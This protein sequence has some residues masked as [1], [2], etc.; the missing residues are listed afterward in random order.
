MFK[1]VEP[2]QSLCSF[3]CN[4]KILTNTNIPSFV[5]SAN[6]DFFLWKDQCYGTQNHCVLPGL[7][8]MV[9]AAATLGGVT[10]MTGIDN[11][12]ILYTVI[13]FI[14]FRS[15]NYLFVQHKLIR[16]ITY[17]HKKKSCTPFKT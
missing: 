11:L 13:F 3:H 16:I 15:C 2:F 7:Y 9:G 4:T 10:R 6:Q 12:N 8:A 1:Q 14:F 17:I 5:F